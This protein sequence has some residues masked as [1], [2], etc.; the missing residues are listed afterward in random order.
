MTG[1][2][3]GLVRLI[4]LEDDWRRPALTIEEDACD[5]AKAS[6]KV[7]LLETAFRPGNEPRG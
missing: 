5:D 7:T 4:D 3:G 1:D 2:E 6:R